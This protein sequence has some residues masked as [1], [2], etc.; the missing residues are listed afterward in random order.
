[1]SLLEAALWYAS[2]GIPA[3]PLLPRSKDP[4]GEKVV[5]EGVER[6]GF[7]LATT[8]EGTIRRWWSENPEYNVA[9]PTG[10][11]SG[12]VV[13]D[14][15]RVNALKERGWTVPPTPAVKTGKGFQYY[16]RH[17][18]GQV[19]NRTGNN[20]L[21]SG[22]E[23]KGDG[24]YIVGPPSVHPNGST[25]EWVIP[26]ED[27][28]LAE[29]PQWLLKAVGE[30]HRRRT[31][32][33]EETIPEG[34]RNDTLFSH[35][36]SLFA[37]GLNDIVVSV[38]IN[39]LNRT[40]CKPP[41][42]DDEVCKIVESA[43]SNKYEHGELY[44]PQ[45][46][47][48]VNVDGINT[49]FDS[50]D[51]AEDEE[52]YKQLIP[53]LM[54][55]QGIHTI[56]GQFGSGKSIL[57]AWIA[58]HAIEQGLTVVYLDEENGLSR[59]RSRFKGLGADRDALKSRLRYMNAPGLTLSQEHVNLWRSVVETVCPG[60]VIFDAMADMLALAG[61]SEND[62][63][64]VTRW[65]KAYCEPVVNAGGAAL[66]LDHIT[67][68]EGVKFARGSTAKLAK[69]DVGWKLKRTLPFNTDTVGE[70]RLT[71]DKD[72]NGNMPRTKVFSIGGNGDGRI[73]VNPGE[74]IE[75][76][77]EDGLTPTQRHIFETIEDHPEGLSYSR[78]QQLSGKAKTTFQDAKSVLESE[79][80]VGQDED[81]KLYY[82]VGVRPTN[83]RPSDQVNGGG[84][85]GSGYYS[86]RPTDLHTDSFI[87]ERQETMIREAYGEM[88]EQP[89]F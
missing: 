17:P 21:A 35:A 74:V 49:L 8:D 73:I 41:L 85:S 46:N 44:I 31:I 6:G 60:L 32:T 65:M 48:Q 76:P 70:V 19:R 12:I 28:E 47:G 52:V 81:T 88:D 11:E 63:V 5:I 26:L 79:G 56:Y 80:L 1:M 37:R 14:E 84:R 13:I 64:D 71:C 3:F 10:P 58:I 62:S 39:A 66:I 61:L 82:V 72:R 78:W 75:T 20:A 4:I 18:G 38:A 51:I 59:M 7:Y 33:V 42:P 83:N 24:G 53:D 2:K 55:E 9:I 16:F 43:G 23:L 29:C 54:Y 89:P 34:S 86:T 36:R 77:D 68:D 87:D 69:V 50:L 25:Y 45:T 40:A 67:K 27:A 30:P 15:D 57:A 22:I